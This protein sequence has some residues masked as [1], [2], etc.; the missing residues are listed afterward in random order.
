MCRAGTPLVF[1]GFW[2]VFPERPKVGRPGF[3]ASD[4][5]DG[6]STVFKP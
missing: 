1:D 2:A 6:F 4:G 3:A 5:D